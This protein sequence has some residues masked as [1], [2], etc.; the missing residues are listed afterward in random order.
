M[1]VIC[2]RIPLA[3]YELQRFYKQAPVAAFGTYLLFY[4]QPTSKLSFYIV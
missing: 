1:E 3:Y 4:S 2:S